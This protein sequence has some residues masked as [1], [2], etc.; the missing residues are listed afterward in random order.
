MQKSLLPW[1]SETFGSSSLEDLI[2]TRAENQTDGKQMQQKIM[3]E[4]QD[5]DNEGF[6]VTKCLFDVVQNSKLCLVTSREVLI[7]GGELFDPRE[8]P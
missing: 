7:F 4:F 8:T 1:V 2:L 3:Q 5:F 6:D